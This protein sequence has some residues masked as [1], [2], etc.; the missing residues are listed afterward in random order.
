MTLRKIVKYITLLVLVGF[1]MLTL[2]LSNSVILD[3][4]NVRAREG[5]YV[6]FVVWSNF[7]SSILYLIAVYGLIKQKSWT[8]GILSISV[9]ILIAAF[10]GLNIHIENGGLYEVKTVNA[11][12]FRIAITIA[13]TISSY[14]LTKKNDEQTILFADNIGG[15]T[16]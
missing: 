10:V 16:L 5:N 2:F 15:I 9:V 3:L 7:I 6:L 11:M 12:I 14:L 1:G 8:A 4:F 13:F